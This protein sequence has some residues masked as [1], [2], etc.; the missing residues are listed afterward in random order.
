MK[1]IPLNAQDIKKPLEHLWSFLSAKSQFTISKF[2][3]S[4]VSFRFFADKRQRISF[5]LSS[6]V[7]ESKQNKKN[8]AKRK[9]TKREWLMKY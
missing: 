3:K 5:F 8:V 6:P 4:T 1:R 7:K 9:D 2:T